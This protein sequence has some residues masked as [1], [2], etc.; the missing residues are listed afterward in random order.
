[1][2]RVTEAGGKL[3]MCVYIRCKRVP[4]RVSRI[5]DTDRPYNFV[6]EQETFITELHARGCSITGGIVDV[7]TRLVSD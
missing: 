5:K 2:R 6:R 4:S 1:M 3:H 7:A